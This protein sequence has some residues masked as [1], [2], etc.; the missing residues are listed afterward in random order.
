MLKWRVVHDEHGNVPREFVSVFVSEDDVHPGRN[1]VIGAFS[2]AYLPIVNVAEFRWD[3]YLCLFPQ[4]R[5]CEPSRK[6][7]PGHGDHLLRCT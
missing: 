1:N 7:L 6:Y 3:L 2:S 4:N 5:Y